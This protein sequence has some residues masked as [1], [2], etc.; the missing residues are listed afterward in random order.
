M[1]LLT[2]K[3]CGKEVS[4]TV[5][6]RPHCG[7]KRTSPLSTVW[8]MIKVIV[9]IFFGLVVYRCA[10]VTSQVT[11]SVN[12]PASAFEQ[13]LPRTAAPA[14]S[15]KDF[16]VSGIKFRREYDSLAFTGTVTN[17]GS[18]ACGVQLK[19]STYDDQGAVV[20]TSDFWPASIRNIA[21]G[22]KE[23][24]SY[25]VRYDKAAKKYE[26]IPSTPKS[27]NDRCNSSWTTDESGRGLKDEI[28]RL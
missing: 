27:G 16:A 17:G 14:C 25:H 6:A 10:S 18:I 15:A 7:A 11:E 5:T 1:A 19:V 8:T 12:P 4:S 20:E 3:E 26:V 21:S 2:C 22:A 23:T 24:F 28:P 13:R 9:A